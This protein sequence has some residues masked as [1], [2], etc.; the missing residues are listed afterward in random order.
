MKLPK[1][2]S[3]STRKSTFL[4]GHLRSCARAR[5]EPDWHFLAAASPPNRPA[6]ARS[7]SSF[8][9]PWLAVASAKTASFRSH[10]TKYRAGRSWAR[11]KEKRALRSPRRRRN[12]RS[13]SG[14]WL[15]RIGRLRPKYVCPLTRC[16]ADVRQ[17][18][19]KCL[20]ATLFPFYEGS[21]LSLKKVADF[22]IRTACSRSWVMIWQRGV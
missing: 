19:V 22:E 20:D 6:P 10:M 16:C 18:N 1:N 15:Q 2:V 21:R 4:I 5:S 8:I 11:E 9:L 7:F 13:D 14:D 12:Q 3:D 17:P